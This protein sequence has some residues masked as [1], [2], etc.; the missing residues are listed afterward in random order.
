M[1]EEIG[2]LQGN[3]TFVLSPVPEGRSIVGGKWVHAVKQGQNDEV[4][5][6]ARFV[7]KGYSQVQDVDYHETFEPTAR[8]TSI[9]MLAKLA[10]QKDMIIHQMDVK[11]AYCTAPRYRSLYGTARRFRKERPKR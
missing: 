2:A 10:V 3:D 6:K 4:K 7:A 5:Y 9:R 11:V 1:N 8:M